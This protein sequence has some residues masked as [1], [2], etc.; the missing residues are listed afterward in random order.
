MRSRQ[1]ERRSRSGMI[2][3]RPSI[4]FLFTFAL[5]L[6][7]LRFGESKEG[8]AMSIAAL[9]L[10][11]AL[12][13]SPGSGASPSSSPD[14][15]A[16]VQQLGASR[17]ADR[18]AA[19]VALERLGAPALPALQAARESRDMEIKT[20]HSPHLL[21]KIETALLTQPTYVRLDYEGRPRSTDLVQSLSRQTGF[22]VALYPQNLPRWKN[23]RV[24]LRRPGLF[25]SGRPSMSSAKSRP[26][27]TT[28]TCS[29]SP[30]GK[31]RGSHSPRGWFAR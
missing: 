20:P 10:L 30:A 5:A 3:Y 16:L 14:P 9:F 1:V 28:R 7:S 21:A 25:P 31:T 27:N 13:Q 6:T 23:Q 19:A 26:C 15:A 8:P 17:F 22:K 12:G 4:A 29:G 24:T 2:G 11:V 18:Q